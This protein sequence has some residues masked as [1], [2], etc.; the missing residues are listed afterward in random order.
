MD[1]QYDEDEVL[2]G[3]VIDP[4]EDPKLIQLPPKRPGIRGLF[5]DTLALSILIRDPRVGMAPKLITA[6]IAIYLLSPI[7]LIPDA[8]PLIGIVDDALVIPAGIRAA[9]VRTPIGALTDARLKVA[10]GEPAKKAIK[11]IL[12]VVGIWLLV[13]G[14]ALYWLWRLFT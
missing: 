5:D 14:F 9:L 2:I 3:E 4:V 7:D 13:A 8:L 11:A 10:T 12:V 1:Y 6:A